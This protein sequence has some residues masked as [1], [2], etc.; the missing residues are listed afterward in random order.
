M[1]F[2]SALLLVFALSS[3]LGR[4]STSSYAQITAERDSVLSEIV[5]YHERQRSSGTANEELI[6]AAQLK[7]YSFRR[8]VAS[9]LVEKIKNQE[10][11]V[12]LFEENLKLIVFKREAGLAGGIQILEAKAALL[13]AKQTLEELR[14]GEKKS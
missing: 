2:K 8:D 9:T 12:R 4:A 10:L 13:E 11:I 5:A 6:A 1:K 7:L 3:S 14:M